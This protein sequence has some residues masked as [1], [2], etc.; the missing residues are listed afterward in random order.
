MRVR[1][2]KPQCNHIERKDLKALVK[3]P[4]RNAGPAFDGDGEGRKLCRVGGQGIAAPDGE[5]LGHLSAVRL[6]GLPLGRLFFQLAFGLM[7]E[8]LVF[9]LRLA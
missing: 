8:F 5:D 4:E 1:S 3:A 7:I 6:L 2:E 9:A